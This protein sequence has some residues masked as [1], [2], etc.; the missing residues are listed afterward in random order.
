[1]L[2]CIAV[3]Q[4]EKFENMRTQSA[5]RKFS[6]RVQLGQLGVHLSS[7]NALVSCR[8]FFEAQDPSSSGHIWTATAGCPVHHLSADMATG[9]GVCVCVCKDA[10][11]FRGNVK[12]AH[13]RIFGWADQTNTVLCANCMSQHNIILVCG[14]HNKNSCCDNAETTAIRL[15]QSQLSVLPFVLCWD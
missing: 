13:C 6:Y 4:L 12:D 2:Y 3:L 9:L 5:R 8:P 10:S 7:T 11:T 15:V 14:G 1:M